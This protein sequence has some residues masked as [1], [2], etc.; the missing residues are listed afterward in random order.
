MSSVL[1]VLG[2]SKALN[3]A[4]KSQKGPF[5]KSQKSTIISTDTNSE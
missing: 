1:E 2:D 4:S 5:P 3:R